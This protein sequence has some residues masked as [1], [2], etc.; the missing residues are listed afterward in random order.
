MDFFAENVDRHRLLC[1]NNTIGKVGIHANFENKKVN[2]FSIL[3][4]IFY[5]FLIMFFTHSGAGDMHRHFLTW[6]EVI[7]K[8]KCHESTIR[9]HIKSGDFPPPVKLF[10][11]KSRKVGFKTADFLLW[12]QGNW[13]TG[14]VA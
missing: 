3:F 5:Q 2:N 7:A 13:N 12:Q 9:R 10:A 1:Y 6:K 14:V 11:G 4:L 8:T